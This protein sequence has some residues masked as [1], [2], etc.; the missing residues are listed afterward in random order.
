MAR[1]LIVE[2]D[3]ASMDLALRRRAPRLP[4]SPMLASA[5]LQPAEAPNTR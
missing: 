2:D 3:P 4:I 1:V 5:Q